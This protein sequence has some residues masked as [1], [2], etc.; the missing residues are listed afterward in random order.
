ML[1]HA[2]CN[3]GFFG[4]DCSQECHCSDG[5]TCAKENGECPAMCAAGWN[6]T[7]CQDGM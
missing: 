1:L 5:D 4:D 2:E 6:G 7:D 3:D